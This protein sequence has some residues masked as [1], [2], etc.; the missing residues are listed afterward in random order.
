ML[1]PRSRNTHFVCRY[2]GERVQE[3]YGYRTCSRNEDLASRSWRK[4]KKRARPY[5]EGTSTRYKASGA[6]DRWR[7]AVT[8][9][10]PQKNAV[11]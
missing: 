8:V 2:R 1:V 3:D 6:R 10:H 4:E 5:E 9:Y 7:T 11:R